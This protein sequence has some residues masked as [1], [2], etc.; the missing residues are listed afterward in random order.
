VATDKYVNRN[1]FGHNLLPI[2]M[3]LRFWICWDAIILVLDYRIELESWHRA[4][5]LAG[6]GKRT[7]ELI[8]EYIKKFVCFGKHSK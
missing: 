3:C 7:S 1:L 6:V 2:L 4:G 8:C 5:E